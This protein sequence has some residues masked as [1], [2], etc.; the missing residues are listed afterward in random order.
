[1]SQRLL[2]NWEQFAQK[3]IKYVTDKFN[4][5]IVVDNSNREAAQENNANAPNNLAPP[6]DNAETSGILAEQKKQTNKPSSAKRRKPYVIICGDLKNVQSSFVIVNEKIHK[7]DSLLKA[8]DLSFK[9]YFSLRLDYSVGCPH[10]WSFFQKCFYEVRGYK[11]I[12]A[13]TKILELFLYV[14]ETKQ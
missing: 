12:V 1:M 13:A 5:P 10:I 8:V 2:V 14:N 6:K 7:C 4:T 9:S 11:Q 3:L